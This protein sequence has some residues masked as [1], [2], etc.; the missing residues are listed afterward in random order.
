MAEVR[1]SSLPS[2]PSLPP[3]SELTYFPFLGRH[4]LRLGNI[5]HHT[6]ALDSSS[7]S[8]F[9]TSSAISSLLAPPSFFCL[10]HL[11][12]SSSP[13]PSPFPP[14]SLTFLPLRLH[15]FHLVPTS[16]PP[17]LLPP[18]LD[19]LP[20][21]L[22]VVLVESRTE[23]SA[24]SLLPFFRRR[25]AREPRFESSEREESDGLCFSRLDTEDRQ[26][27]SLVS[28]AKLS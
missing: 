21:H 20:V 25:R 5:Q 1:L 28:T 8:S 14:P 3:F 9:S 11:S 10:L 7:L 17:P 22:P 27:R 2:F 15:F 18:P 4:R 16:F 23:H 6:L 12:L 19:N 13:P 26:A 24:P